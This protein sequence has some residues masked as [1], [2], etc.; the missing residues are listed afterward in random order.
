L[1]YWLPDGK[2]IRCGAI[3]GYLNGVRAIGWYIPLLGG[4]LPL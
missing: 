1:G 3:T 2:A 4:N